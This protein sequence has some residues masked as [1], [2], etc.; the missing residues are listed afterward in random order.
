MSVEEERRIAQ[1]FKT[2][3]IEAIEKFFE[4]HLKPDTRAS[5]TDIPERRLQLA[6]AVILIEMT[7]ADLDIK[8]E[9]RR[10]V[11]DAIQQALHLSPEETTEIVALAKKQ[12]ERSVPLYLFV[13]LIDKEFSFDQKKLLI[14]QMWRVAFSDAQIMAHEEYLIRKVS[15]LLHVPLADFLDA[16]IRARDAFK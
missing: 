1:E 13:R 6:A 3:M 10:A 4:T 16:K 12:V 9:E 8:E 5:S 14:E 7:R 15:D 2:A 11:T